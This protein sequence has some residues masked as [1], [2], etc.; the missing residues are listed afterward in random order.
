MTSQVKN[1]ERRRNI[2][3]ENRVEYEKALIAL[4]ERIFETEGPDM[5]EEIQDKINQWFV[6]TRNPENGEYNSLREEDGGVG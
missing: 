6:E 1:L 3:Q 4:K 5:K 2:Q